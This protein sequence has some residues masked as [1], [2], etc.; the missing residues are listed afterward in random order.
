MMT[1][2]MKE[3]MLLSLFQN[4]VLLGLLVFAT[5]FDPMMVWQY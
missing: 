4:L 1:K 5:G 2:R 3:R